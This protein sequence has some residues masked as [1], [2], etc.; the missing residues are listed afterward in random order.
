MERG[1]EMQRNVTG[2]NDIL[3]LNANGVGPDAVIIRGPARESL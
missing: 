3:E 1:L 2:V